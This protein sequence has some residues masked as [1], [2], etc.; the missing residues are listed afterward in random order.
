MKTFLE[1]IQEDAATHLPVVMAFGRMNPPTVGHEKL[2]NKVKE[3]AKDYR[4]PHHIILSHS[5]DAKK[6]PLTV[7]QK[8]KHAKRLFPNTNI[9]ASSKETPTFLQHAAKLNAAGHDHLIMVGGS[10][11]VKEFHDKLHQY[12]GTHRSEEHTSELQSH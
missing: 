4:A 11:R 12:N 3:V 9:E 8:V 5:T 2:V 7:S 1:K 6:N 10:D